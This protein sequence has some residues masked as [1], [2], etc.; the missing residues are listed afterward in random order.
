[1][2]Q[3]ST[4]T[5]ELDVMSGDLGEP[6][7]NWENCCV[8]L[9]AKSTWTVWKVWKVAQISTNLEKLRKNDDNVQCLESV[10][11]AKLYNSHMF[12]KQPTHRS[13]F[14]KLRDFKRPSHIVDIL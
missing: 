11:A 2:E 9:W 13:L 5:A 10:Q 7:R 4:A 8:F 12:V 1:M 6:K 3:P 14:G